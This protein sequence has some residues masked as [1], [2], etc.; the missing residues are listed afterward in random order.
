M[1]P[2]GRKVNFCELMS[3]NSSVSA[4]PV[5]IMMSTYNG[6]Q[7]LAE[8]LESILAQSYKSWTLLIRDDGS[9][10]STGSLID[11]F[12]RRD[13]RIG[14]L[15]DD[16][17][18]LGPWASF[19]RMLEA[20]LSSKYSYFFFADQDD[21]WRP[22]KIEMQLAA[23]RVAEGDDEERIPALVHS[24]LEVVDEQLRT[25]HPSL[26][27][28]QRLSYD[29]ADPLGTLL[30]RNAVVGCTT[31]FNRGLLEFA[32]PLPP[33]SPHDWWLAVSTAALGRMV[34]IPEPTVRYRQ[35]GR[36]AVGART[37][38]AF[39]PALLRHP[40]SFIDG[41]VREFAIGVGQAAD[42]YRRLVERGAGDTPVAARVAQYVSAFRAGNDLPER[43]T[44]LKASRIK[45]RRRFSRVAMLGLVAAFPRLHNS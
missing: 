44:A 24:E 43:L 34:W 9:T 1:A 40:R 17:G 42:L 13:S 10:D 25:I 2:A 14:R 11:E 5:L 26:H 33:G 32:V 19:G 29:E 3:P 38:H 27:D 31:G 12:S 45:P 41:A 37:R 30:I 35:H 6:S 39:I 23:L 28:F 21:V 7:Y 20:A 16:L 22:H 8:Q 4:L 18:N 36:N 15:Q